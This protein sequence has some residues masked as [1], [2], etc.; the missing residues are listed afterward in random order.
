MTSM[1]EIGTTKLI[2]SVEEFFKTPNPN[3]PYKPLPEH[4]LEQS[5]CRSIITVKPAGKFLL[6]C[7]EI[8][9]PEFANVGVVASIYL[10]SLEH[11]CLYKDA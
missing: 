3:E 7:C 2:V 6:Y 8:C 9:R 11:H 10:D 1:I 5:P 4:T